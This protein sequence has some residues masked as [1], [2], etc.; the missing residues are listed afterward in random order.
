M[1]F[2]LLKVH[3]EVFDKLGYYLYGIKAPDFGTE[4]DD[5]VKQLIGKSN[6]KKLSFIESSVPN[7]PPTRFNPLDSYIDEDILG[8]SDQVI[9]N[10][11]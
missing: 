8:V 6:L 9:I 3:I 5:E 1:V 10:F 7:Q 2:F 4:K 11:F